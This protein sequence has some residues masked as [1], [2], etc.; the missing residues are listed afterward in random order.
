MSCRQDQ[1]EVAFS[2]M[3]STTQENDELLVSVKLIKHEFANAKECQCTFV[4][5]T[6]PIL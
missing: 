5:V 6:E 1:K 3:P 2:S 4:L